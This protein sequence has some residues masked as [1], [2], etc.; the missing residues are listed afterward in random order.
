[1]LHIFIDMNMNM[2]DYKSIFVKL[3]NYFQLFS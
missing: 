3:L 1:M 2:N